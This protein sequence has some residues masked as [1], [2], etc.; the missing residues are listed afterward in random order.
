MIFF[1]S[2]A[3]QADGQ[4]CTLT[5]KVTDAYGRSPIPGATVRVD[6]ASGG[7][8]D[9]QGIYVSQT[10]QKPHNLTISMIGFREA[11][12]DI[13]LTGVVDTLIR[14]KLYPVTYSLDEAVV[15]ASRYRQ[16]LSDL[17]VSL[18]ALPA[19]FIR[20]TQTTQISEAISRLPGVEVLDGQASIRGGSG[21][22]FGA[23]SRVMMLVDGLPLLT[24]DVG[25]VKWNFLPVEII[26]RTEVLKGA[27]SALYGSS[28]LNG[29]VNLLTAWPEEKRGTRISLYSGLTMKPKRTETAW[30]WDG[31]PI[32][33]G[34]EGA[35]GIKNIHSD[36]VFGTAYHNDDGYRDENYEQRFRANLKFRHRPENKPMTW[37]L[38]S[39]IQWQKSSDFLIW[40]DAD[41]GAFLQ[42]SQAISPSR[43]FRVWVDPWITWVPDNGSKHSVKSRYYSVYNNF[44]DVPDKNNGS[45]M[46]YGEYLYNSPANR[47]VMF[48]GGFSG[49]AG[50]AESNLYGDHNNSTTAIFA[51]ADYK[52][53]SVW[54][55]TAGIRQEFYTLDRKERENSTVFRAGATYNA[56]EHTFLRISAGEGFRFPSIAEKYT[57]TSLGSLL[58]FPN[59]GLEHEKGWN[60]EAGIR[61]GFGKGK[62]R[63]WVDGAFFLTEYEKMIE[64]TFG[65]WD[66][67]EGGIP[68]L[69]N[70]G[71]KALN[72]GK[73]RVYGAETTVHL[74]L[75]RGPWL[76]KSFAG[77]TW[78]NP[79]DLDA[80]T[81]E[82]P[83]LKYRYRHTAKADAE[84]ARGKWSA[85]L[86]LLYHSFMERIDEAFEVELF[87]QEIFPG[88]KQYRQDNNTG[89]LV[90]DLRA[91]YSAGYGI[92]I[93][94]MINNLFNEEYM[95]RPGD[96]RPPRNIM[97]RVIWNAISIEDKKEKALR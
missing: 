84:I 25:E 63:G 35:V 5:V 14:V 4:Q 10:E 11:V 40:Q 31:L 72:T 38:S 61:Q 23:G 70:L 94:L 68:T 26:D 54:S 80:D 47:K 33:T 24:A 69:E 85:G 65:V 16:K 37:G 44:S 34:A 8:T 91:G 60:A 57:S 20:S 6:S 64:Y 96:I 97:L 90:T 1:L 56:A 79:I 78:L 55:F 51:Q 71:F 87:G 13:D 93:N 32:T 74:N 27:S 88:L 19:D 62:T 21:Y 89:H 59:P 41:S 76:L 29:V 3:F 30:W 83:V 9:Y 82:N 66:V 92:S 36:L 73:A 75:S 15:T 17:P 52:P 67:P 28:A 42:L 48:T 50:W 49:W 45:Q 2:V 18:E 39:N 58:I 46:L 95:G 43:G 86:S 22:S 81:L 7:F 77:Y 12:M 53:T